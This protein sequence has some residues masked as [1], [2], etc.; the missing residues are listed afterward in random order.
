MVFLEEINTYN[1]NKKNLKQKIPSPQTKNL[2]FKKTKNPKN[3]TLSI[4]IL[5]LENFNMILARKWKRINQICCL[6]NKLTK[7]GRC[8]S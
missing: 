1:K 4:K 2:I 3:L 5:C 7:L 8:D 6:L